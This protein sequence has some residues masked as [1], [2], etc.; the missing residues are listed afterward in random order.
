MRK[1]IDNKKCF[2]EGIT[3]RMFQQINFRVLIIDTISHST[4]ILLI[5]SQISQKPIVTFLVWTEHLSC[6]SILIF[7]NRV[8]QEKKENFLRNKKLNENFSEIQ[9]SAHTDLPKKLWLL[10]QKTEKKN[11]QHVQ[12]AIVYKPTELR[13]FEQEKS[14][15]FPQAY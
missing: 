4:H 7:L 12:M 10:C 11:D 3:Q 2:F 9:N 8:Q 14:E 15:I 5:L 13:S 1:I 6:H